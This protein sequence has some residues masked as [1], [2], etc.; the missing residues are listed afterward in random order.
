MYIEYVELASICV[1]I[2]LTLI[3]LVVSYNYTLRSMEIGKG[4]KTKEPRETK[5]VMGKN[6][7]DK[8]D[9]TVTSM[10]DAGEY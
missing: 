2:I 7:S 10:V 5:T 3:A 8:S 4:K 9:E 6:G 1:A